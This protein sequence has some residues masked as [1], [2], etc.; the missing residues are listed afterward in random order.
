MLEIHVLE[1]NDDRSSDLEEEDSSPNFLTDPEQ[2]LDPHIFVHA[3][4]GVA[5]FKIMRVTSYFK[6]RPI[7]ILIDS[8]NTHN[9]RN[10]QL[11]TKMGCL[12]EE[13]SPLN[14]VVADGTKAL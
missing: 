14:V 13:I 1:V 12:L 8:G 3:L 2:S 4:T 5:N 9:F 10:A 11:A 7:H 6:K